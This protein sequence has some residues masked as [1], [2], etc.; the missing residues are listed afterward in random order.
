MVRAPACHAGG[1]RFEPDPGRFV[2][3]PAVHRAVLQASNDIYQHQAITQLL[4]KGARGIVISESNLLLLGT[5]LSYDD[6]TLFY[7]QHLAPLKIS[8]D[9]LLEEPAEIIQQEKTD[10]TEENEEE[11]GTAESGTTGVIETG[12]TRTFD[13]GTTGT[14]DNGTINNGTT[15]TGTTESGTTGTQGTDADIKEE[16]APKTTF[17]ND[18]SLDLDSE[19]YDLDGF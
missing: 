15:G 5:S 2:E 3:S 6:Y 14:F 8:K 10:D 4:S 1:R 7:T 17:D 18:D 16:K 12:T 19:K 13:N 9:P 11:T